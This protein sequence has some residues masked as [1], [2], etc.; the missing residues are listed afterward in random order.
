MGSTVESV[1][2][3]EDGAQAE[4]ATTQPI[5]C[6]ACQRRGRVA[7]APRASCDRWDDNVPERAACSSVGLPS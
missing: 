6:D 5:A 1:S 4:A 3:C 2:T 7:A